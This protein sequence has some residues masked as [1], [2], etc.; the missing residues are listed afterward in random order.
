MGVMMQAQGIKRSVA[1]L[2]AGFLLAGTIAACVAGGLS[3]CQAA[4]EKPG[5]TSVPVSLPPPSAAQTTPQDYPGLHNVVAFSD[6]VYSGSVPEGDAGFESLRAMGI[7]TVLSVD[8]ALPEL[9]RSKAAGL[10]YVHLP[11]GYNGFDDA[12]RLELTRVVRDLPGPIY[13]HCHHGK[14]RSAAAA[15]AAAVSLGRMTPD[16]AVARMKVS[17]TAPAYTGLYACVASATQ[18]SNRAIDTASAA[19]PE[20][21][22]PSGMVQSMVAI[23]D[24]TEHLKLIEK[25]GWI[26]PS[27]HPDLVPVAEAGRMADVLRL[28]SE[29]KKVQREPEGFRT[30]LAAAAAAAQRLEDQLARPPVDAKRASADMAIIVKSCK[31]CHVPY[32]D[33]AP[34]SH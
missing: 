26:T 16:E 33:A 28:L 23:D 11:I 27:D 32:R 17:G 21:S 5:A 14:H 8:G 29:D 4:P 1:K 18:Q 9:D 30:I 6:G 3:G 25:A 24:A 7:R 34:V 15:G 12:R 22:M 13:I 2:A 20:A 31:E 10:R 19:F